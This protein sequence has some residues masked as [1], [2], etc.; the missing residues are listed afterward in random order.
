MSI[1]AVLFDLD[2]TLLPMDLNVFVKRYFGLLAENM[3]QYGYNPKQLIDAVWAGIG[4]MTNN[5]GTKTNEQVF[6]DKFAEI[7][8]EQVR[9]DLPRF[10]NFYENYFDN[11][12]DSCGFNDIANKVVTTLKNKNYKLC[13]ATS[14]IFPATATYKRINWAGLN[15]K[16]FELVTTYEN[17]SYSKPNIEYYLQIL[18]KLGVDASDCLMVGNDVNEDMV[19]IKLGIKVYLVTDCLINKNNEDINKYNR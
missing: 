12:K 14:P 19:A 13:L 17:S 2:G 9:E 18:N 16:D 8:G 4:V 5:N 1:K 10:Q 11:A 3:A 15:S 7:F 6:W